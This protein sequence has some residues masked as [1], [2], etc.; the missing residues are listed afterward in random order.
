MVE[1]LYA[2]C[3]YSVDFDLEDINLVVKYLSDLQDCPMALLEECSKVA[4]LTV[5]DLFPNKTTIDSSSQG[6][7]QQN[8]FKDGLVNEGKG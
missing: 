4:G 6:K 3:Q 2:D 7:K 1:H 5:L 8:V